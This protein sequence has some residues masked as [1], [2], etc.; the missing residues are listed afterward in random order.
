MATYINLLRLTQRG[1][2]NIKESPARVEAARKIYEQMGAKI[3]DFY[4][5]MGQYDTV[6]IAE[7]PDDETMAK[8]QLALGSLGNVRSE[9]LR[10][11]TETEYRKIV[12][13]LP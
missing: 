4:C 5:V 6:L 7:A 12:A 10:A 11:F 2:E 8:I 1:I 9:T 3:K 13:S